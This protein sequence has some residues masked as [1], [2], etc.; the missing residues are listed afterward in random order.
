MLE[1]LGLCRVFEC[2]RAIDTAHEARVP[3]R[4]TRQPTVRDAGQRRKHQQQ[5]RQP[6]S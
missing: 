5:D 1:R 6:A 3:G 4:T 2:G